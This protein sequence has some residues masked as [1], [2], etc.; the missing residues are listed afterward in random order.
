MIATRIARNGVAMFKNSG[1]IRR[2]TVM[3]TAVAFASGIGV[4][5]ASATV[6]P[7][8]SGGGCS[9]YVSVGYGWSLDSCIS[10]SSGTVKPDGYASAGTKGSGCT[11]YVDLIKNGS[12]IGTNSYSCSTTHV[13]GPTATGSGTYFTGIYVVEG[14]NYT[15]EAT[16]PNEYN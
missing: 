16:S 12:V 13:Y 14:G 1:L 2:L 10:A 8:S 11:I 9:G 5:A 7:L 4:T 15:S 6:I 3:G